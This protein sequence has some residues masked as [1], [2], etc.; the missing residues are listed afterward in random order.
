MNLSVYLQCR[1]ANSVVGEAKITHFHWDFVKIKRN[2]FE[3]PI[4][5]TQKKIETLF[6]AC[7]CLLC[8]V[9]ESTSIIFVKSSVT[10]GIYKTSSEHN[11]S[12]HRK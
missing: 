1:I 6:C 10:S 12:V 9:W 8:I 4:V 2:C 7:I 5:N 3:K 11:R